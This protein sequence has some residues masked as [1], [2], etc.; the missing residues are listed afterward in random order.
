[1]RGESEEKA[2]ESDVRRAV[3]HWIERGSTFTAFDVAELID[4]GRARHLLPSVVALMRALYEEGV[5]EDLGYRRTL[6]KRATAEGVM[7][8]VAFAPKRSARAGSR[9]SHPPQKRKTTAARGMQPFGYLGIPLKDTRRLE[10]QTENLRAHL[11]ASGRDLV[12]VGEL[13]AGVQSL[14]G[15]SRAAQYFERELAISRDTARRMMRVAHAFHG[16][17]GMESVAAVRPSL[18][19]KLT[20]PSFP[21]ELKRA[22]LDQRSLVIDG[23]RTPL[24]SLRPRDLT[25]AKKQWLDRLKT[26]QQLQHRIAALE[27][28]ESKSDQDELGVMRARLSAISRLSPTEVMTPGRNERQVEALESLTKGAAKL[29][30]QIDVLEKT[31][32]DDLKRAGLEALRLLIKELEK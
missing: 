19:Y 15:V 11:S 23:R 16:H 14:L 18:L 7:T 1:V 30:A 17:A 21:G 31:L 25:L 22:I 10:R 5:F 8:T 28:S 9:P 2:R 4:R 32:P 13:L 20:E 24:E 27:E 12:R 3:L 6:S 29:A 26:R